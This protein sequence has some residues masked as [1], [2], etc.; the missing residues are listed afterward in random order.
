MSPY[1]RTL[2][3]KVIVREPT[4][5]DLKA[6]YQRCIADKKKLPFEKALETPAFALAIKNAARAAIIRSGGK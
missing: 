1:Q 5:D 2:E 3:L 6:A 4:I